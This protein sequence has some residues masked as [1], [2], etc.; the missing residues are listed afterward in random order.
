MSD[1]HVP[2]HAGG[3]G[4][5]GGNR[6]T[7]FVA[8]DDDKIR[9]KVLDGVFDAAEDFVVDHVASI[10]DHEEIAQSCVENQFGRHARIGASEDD[11]VRMLAR[12]GKRMAAAE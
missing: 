7:L 2:L 10:A 11:G 9:A 8:E 5:G 6:A 3:G 4:D 1:V 12:A